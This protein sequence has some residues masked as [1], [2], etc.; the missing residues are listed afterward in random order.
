MTV[1]N[2]TYCLCTG[3]TS[4]QVKAVVLV[5]VLVSSC[6]VGQVGSVP[7]VIKHKSSW[8]VWHRLCV[9]TGRGHALDLGKRTA[10]ATPPAVPMPLMDGERLKRVRD[11]VLEAKRAASVIKKVMVSFNL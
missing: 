7:I 3:V 11:T 5:T 2:V 6:L 4:D 1:C 10:E 8:D 9:P